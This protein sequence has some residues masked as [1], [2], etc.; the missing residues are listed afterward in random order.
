MFTGSLAFTFLKVLKN[1]NIGNSFFDQEGSKHIHQIIDKAN[2]KGVQIFFPL[3]FVCGDRKPEKCKT[4][5]VDANSGVSEGW[6]GMDIGPKS[7]DLIKS[8]IIKSK[9]TLLNGPPGV[10]EN[11]HFQQGTIDIL[12]TMIEATNNGILTFAAGEDTMNAL[13]LVQGV[14]SILTHV[15]TGGRA[16][17]ILLEG[18]TLPG[19][20]IL[21]QKVN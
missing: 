13:R 18:K 16:S 17:L 12:N 3:D 6:I 1:F 11:I 5:I 7:R 8:L 15:S 19:I 4:E 2:K 20:D 21:S 10:F 14:E 9:T